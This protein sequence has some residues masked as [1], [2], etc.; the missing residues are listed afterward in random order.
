MNA[1][2]LYK[3]KWMLVLNLRG[4]SHHSSRLVLS[5]VE[6]NVVGMNTT[7]GLGIVVAGLVV[8]TTSCWKGQLILV[9]VAFPSTV[10]WLTTP[11][12]QTIIGSG[13]KSSGW[14][15]W[16]PWLPSWSSRQTRCSIRLPW[17]R[18]IWTVHAVRDPYLTLLRGRARR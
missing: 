3:I 5:F 6:I 2:H 18:C 15:S 8:T 17:G 11:E 14:W 4:V 13:S 12:A 16:K 1:M 9:L 10:S 7:I